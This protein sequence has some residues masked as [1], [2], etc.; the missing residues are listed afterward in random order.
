V[1][2]PHHHIPIVILSAA[3]DLNLQFTMQFSVYGVVSQRVICLNQA[4]RIPSSLFFIWQ[5]GCYIEESRT[6]LQRQGK[7]E[8]FGFD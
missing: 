4:K 6:D 8:C 3:K 2:S 5:R 1:R 7:F